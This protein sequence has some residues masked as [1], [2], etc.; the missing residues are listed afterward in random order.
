MKTMDKTIAFELE[1]DGIV[2]CGNEW[3]TVDE[4]VQRE[5]QAAVQRANEKARVLAE[6]AKEVRRQY[7]SHRNIARARAL[8]MWHCRDFPLEMAELALQEAL[9][10]LDTMA[11]ENPE[12]E[13]LN[14]DGVA[15]S[16]SEWRQAF[17]WWAWIELN[18]DVCC[19]TQKR[20]VARA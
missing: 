20:R 14:A 13:V 11:E 2:L 17:G 4:I 19:N 5:V 7:G 6:A 12:M 1:A 3:T 18:V 15:R 16:Y 8:A 9:A 10:E